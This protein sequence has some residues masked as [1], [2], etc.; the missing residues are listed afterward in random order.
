M[1]LRFSPKKQLAPR[2][3]ATHLLPKGAICRFG[4][5]QL[6]EGALSP[7]GQYLAIATSIGIELLD[8]KSGDIVRMFTKVGEWP[9]SLGFNANGRLLASGYKSGIVRAW[10]VETGQQ[11]F[12]LPDQEDLERSI[13]LSFSSR[14]CG[15]NITAWEYADSPLLKESICRFSVPSHHVDRVVSVAFSPNGKLLASGSEDAKK[16]VIIWDIESH[17]VLHILVGHPEFGV[18]VGTV[19]FSPDGQLLASGCTE[20]GKIAIWAV[21]QGELVRVLPGH[22]AYVRCAKFS[23]NGQLIASAGANGCIRLWEAESGR[24]L[25]QIEHTGAPDYEAGCLAF[26][27]DGRFLIAGSKSVLHGRNNHTISM[28]DVKTGEKVG[29]KAAH[30][31][32]IESVIFSTGGWSVFSCSRDGKVREWDIRHDWSMRTLCEYEH[33]GMSAVAITSDNRHVQSGG[34]EDSIT[35]IWKIGTGHVQQI[36]IG[37]GSL[38]STLAF[39]PTG[40]QAALGYED[41]TIELWD[42]PS[43]SLVCKLIGLPDCGVRTVAY[44][45]DGEILASGAN[46][47]AV[48]LWEA[49]TGMAIHSLK[50]HGTWISVAFLSDSKRLVIGSWDGF[51]K[52][53]DTQT[54]ELLGSIKESEEY[55]VVNS[56]AIS[57]DDRLLAA[58]SMFHGTK[59]WDLDTG[60]LLQILRSKP[61]SELHCIETVAFSPDGRILACGDSRSRIMLWKLESGKVIRTLDGHTDRVLGLAFSRN[62]E[63][64]ASCSLDGTVLLWRTKEILQKHT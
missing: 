32:N 2:N 6:S 17:R 9:T 21:R 10:D 53:W 34:I 39:D 45:P 24:L 27:P 38:I 52:M 60:C 37:N 63:A 12:C 61:D 7:D 36:L 44:S 1:T 3:R 35:N 28:W 13:L 30:C 31:D 25:R 47:G 20:N 62:G 59:V 46:D 14:D 42:I 22:G 49:K 57:P 64:L 29:E 8:S 33:G 56:V 11:V 18:I 15:G 40:E 43:V 19:A 26:S 55:E 41:G 16:A 4:K 5:G 51:V 50:G 48:C 58:G 54:A 23:P